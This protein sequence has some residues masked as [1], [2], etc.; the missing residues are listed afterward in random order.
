MPKS[1]G[2]KKGRGKSTP[3]R[4]KKDSTLGNPTFSTREGHAYNDQQSIDI[5]T[6]GESVRVDSNSCS[7]FTPPISNDLIENS[8]IKD[9]SQ[10]YIYH[11]D[12]VAEMT[13]DVGDFE[14]IS[15]DCNEE[16]C[17]KARKLRL[18][19]DAISPEGMPNI[20]NVINDFLKSG[21]AFDAAL[22]EKYVGL[23]ALDVEWELQSYVAYLNWCEEKLQGYLKKALFPTEESR[24]LS[25]NAWDNGYDLTTDVGLNNWCDRYI[26]KIYNEVRYIT[27]SQ[28]T[29]TLPKEMT[30]RVSEYHDTLEE[31]KEVSGVEKITMDTVKEFN[32]DTSHFGTTYTGDVKPI[33][34]IVTKD[35][36]GDNWIQEIFC[37]R[38]SYYIEHED[39]LIPPCMVVS[40]GTLTNQDPREKFDYGTP[41]IPKA[42]KLRWEKW[43][44]YMAQRCAK[45]AME[46]RDTGKAFQIDDALKGAFDSEE[47]AQF[48]RAETNAFMMGIG[49]PLANRDM[50]LWLTEEEAKKHPEQQ[51]R[52]QKTPTFSDFVESG[53][54]DKVKEISRLSVRD[55]KK[56]SPDRSNSMTFNFFV[57]NFSIINT[58]GVKES[59]SIAWQSLGQSVQIGI[60]NDL[61]IWYNKSFAYTLDQIEAESP[62]AA[63][64]FLDSMI[65]LVMNTV[66]WLNYISKE[67]IEYVDSKKKE[68]EK[69][70]DKMGQNIPEFDEDAVTEE[71]EQR[72]LKVPLT[73]KRTRPDG[74]K[75][76]KAHQ[77]GT[78]ASPYPHVGIL[79]GDR[80]KNN[81]TWGFHKRK[82]FS[83]IKGVRI[84]KKGEFCAYRINW[85]K[86]HPLS[87]SKSLDDVRAEQNKYI[88]D[89]GN[90][91][92]SETQKRGKRVHQVLTIGEHI[93]EVRSVADLADQNLSKLKEKRTSTIT[94]KNIDS[95]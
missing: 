36:L 66:F 23:R 22:S 47:Y 13:K 40:T 39:K 63:V 73:F 10:G 81:P 5:S 34:P 74:R 4:R 54:I 50:G 29:F 83:G 21:A 37:R 30:R 91:K 41:I 67:R 77:G 32:L 75:P 60:T 27:L 33:L 57:K 89:R 24:R 1:K 88:H 11:R 8:W 45:H 42:V 70:R 59:S 16:K 72:W 76:R 84:D 53:K 43:K 9:K 31:W 38:A 35:D 17:L 55:W 58:K 49:L 46:I 51:L 69:K 19:H 28:A 65:G 95:A 90:R 86:D 56:G 62:P 93:A 20:K 18:S 87:G 44:E 15:T 14:L 79:V 68:N 3:Q 94:K 12:L 48:T 64:Q 25:E 71:Y 92:S 52:S 2:R 61:S 82:D 80:Y 7:T 6:T 26:H 78:H 85:P